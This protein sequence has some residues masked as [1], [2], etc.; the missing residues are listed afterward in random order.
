MTDIKEIYYGILDEEDIDLLIKSKSTLKLKAKRPVLIG[1]KCLLKVNMNI[2]VSNSDNYELELKKLTEISKLS[3]RPD[4]MMDHTIVPLEKPLWK[5][6]V[7]IFDGAVGTLPHYLPF[8]EKTGIDEAEFFDN[9]IQMAQGGVS[10]MTLHPTADLKLYEK[11]VKGKRIVPTTSRGGYVLLKDQAINHRK[12]NIIAENFEKIMSIFKENNVAV[13]IGTVFRPATIHEALDEYHIEE[14]EM[15]KKYIRIAKKYGVHVMM[16]GIGHISIDKMNEYANLIRKNEA[17][18]M[19]LGP[20][21]SDE[22][23][24]FDH[25]SNAVGIISMAQTGVLGMV[26]SVTR[27]EHTGKVPSF[28]SILEG[29]MAA[30]TAAHCYNI[31]KFEKYKLKTEVIGVTRGNSLSCVQR[32]GIF[33][34]SN[35]DEKESQE[36]SRCRHECPLKEIV[37]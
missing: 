2:G 15:Q 3:Y 36:C 17:P 20:M 35:I 16:E 34:Y 9:L 6:M 7:E 27:E 32:G 14:I 4:S 10:F 26:N 11:A 29:L 28:D 18:L 13:S 30:K 5:S 1:T 21:P 23:I 37:I 33:N 22:I 24:G 12:Q 25:V 19:P 31:S 8:N